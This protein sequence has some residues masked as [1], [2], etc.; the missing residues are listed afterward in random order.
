M[1]SLEAVLDAHRTAGFKLNKT[2]LFRKQVDFLS[3]RVLD[4]GIQL[5]NKYLETI[6]NFQAQQTEKS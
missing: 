1:G 6:K 4:L 3:F 5:T 2:L